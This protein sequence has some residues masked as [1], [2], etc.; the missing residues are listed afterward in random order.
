MTK[1]V[2]GELCYSLILKRLRCW[3]DFYL[4]HAPEVSL[5]DYG[6]FAD[7]AGLINTFK[8]YANGKEIK[9]QVHVREF[10]YKTEKEGREEG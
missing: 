5:Y 4:A 3:S 8:I 9:P 7:T 10:L 1:R 6:D 2:K